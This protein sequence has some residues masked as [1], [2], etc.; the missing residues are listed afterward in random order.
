MHT[1]SWWLTIPAGVMTSLPFAADD[2]R[3]G[4]NGLAYA[5]RNVAQLLLMCDRQD[6]GVSV[7]T[8]GSSVRA[9]EARQLPGTDATTIDPRIFV[10]D[11]YPGGIGF[12]A[13]LFDMQD[14]LLTSTADLIRGCECER[15]CPSC[16]GP[17]GE[18]G[19][20][21]KR[22]ALAILQRVAGIALEPHQAPEP[23]EDRVPF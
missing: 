2:R 5:M 9:S 3:D 20:L 8:D 16:V 4:V 7:D 11:N 1:S 22:V 21:G 18:I 10:Y 14:R 15:G 19:P 23:D 12:S 17:I 13:P 6:I